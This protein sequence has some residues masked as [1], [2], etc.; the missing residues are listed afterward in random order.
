MYILVRKF[1]YKHFE[2]I[3]VNKIEKKVYKEERK[4]IL[5]DILEW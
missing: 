2:E 4:Y 5:L 1:F 3:F